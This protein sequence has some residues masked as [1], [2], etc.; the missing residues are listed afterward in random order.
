VNLYGLEYLPSPPED[1]EFSRILKQYY[2]DGREA[3]YVD[4]FISADDRL[5]VLIWWVL[6]G[7]SFLL[8]YILNS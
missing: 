4:G 3:G 7:I 1:Q 2:E 8:G 5:P 6:I